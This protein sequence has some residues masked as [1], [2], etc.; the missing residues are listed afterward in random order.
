MGEK[1]IELAEDLI[2]ALKDFIAYGCS[3]LDLYKYSIVL[4]ERNW[5]QGRK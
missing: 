3:S 4:D 2:A 5:P 1:P